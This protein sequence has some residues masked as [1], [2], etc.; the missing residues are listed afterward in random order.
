MGSNT[1]E[2]VFAL[3]GLAILGAV[4]LVLVDQFGSSGDGRQPAQQSPA[5]ESGG[6]KAP[7]RIFLETPTAAVPAKQP[8]Q[9][10]PTPSPKP[11]FTPAPEFHV[12]QA[13]ETLLSIAVQYGISPD[14]L[15]AKNKLEDPNRI[16]AGQRL[17]LP[18]SGEEFAQPEGGKQDDRTYIVKEGDTLFAIS[19][20][21]SVTVEALME[22]NN[23][24]DVS[25]L[26]VGRRLKIPEMAT[27]R[28]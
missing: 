23:I 9:P 8:E 28:P 27:P 18:R 12:V 1:R 10:T 3:L 20:E 13:G 21:F 26:F 16:L 25:K 5:N 14:A 17:A 6:G 7:T 22:A 19:Q 15:A 4:A 11:T 24:A 2:A